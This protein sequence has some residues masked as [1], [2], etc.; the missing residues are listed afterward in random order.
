MVGFLLTAGC[1]EV[2]EWF[3]SP[4]YPSGRGDY[5]SDLDYCDQV[6]RSTLH[7][8]SEISSDIGRELETGHTIQGPDTLERNIG[9]YEE[10][11]RFEQIVAECLRHRR[12]SGPRG[13]NR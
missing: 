11:K 9:S 2:V 10:R 7:A 3:D 13:P 8:E 4:G 5:A 12:A 6:A 1:S